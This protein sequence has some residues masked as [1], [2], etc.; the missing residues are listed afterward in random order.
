[1]TI[2]T[3]GTL[4][5]GI[6]ST[7]SSSFT[8]ATATNTLASGDFGILVVVT[9]NRSNFSGSYD[10]T[11]VSGGT[12]GWLKLDEYT[13]TAGVAGD[14]VAVSVWLFEA[15]GTVST[16]TTITITLSGTATDKAATFWKFTK[17][18]GK[19]IRLSPHAN[20]TPIRNTTV[21]S[22]GFGS[23]SFASLSSLSRLYL[24]GLGKEA[25]IGTT[26]FTAST[27]FTAMTMI[28]SR[29]NA[30]AVGALGEFRINTSTGETSNP[31]LAIA[32]DTAGIFLALEE[33][34]PGTD[35]SWDFEVST[36]TCF[37]DTA[38]T[39]AVT[40]D[41]DLVAAI[42]DKNTGRIIETQATSTDRPIYKT[43][44][45]KPYLDMTSKS[46]NGMSNVA[47]QCM[48]A[49]TGRM[50]IGV[51]VNFDSNTGTQEV[52]HAT[53]GTMAWQGPRN[54]TGS[55]NMLLPG[56]SDTGPSITAAQGTVLSALCNTTALEAFVDG[57]GNGSSSRTQGVNINN[58][59]ILNPF[60]GK[61]YGFKIYPGLIDSTT[62]T[63]MVSALQALYTAAGGSTGPWLYATI[64]E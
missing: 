15:T 16:G 2:A 22:N 62:H 21:G 11:G 44:G 14:G 7:S 54:T 43:G 6:S 51:A 61:L 45:G 53:N 63:A 12:G 27:N 37:T 59:I 52:I 57:T 38:G 26:G 19:G 60:A 4:G 13:Y 10:H 64:L 34:T 42:K 49:A 48:E 9:D 5:T 41:G 17:A 40:S 3:G 30:S 58:G 56:F 23:V 36:A 46:F 25:N 20:G 28:R 33:Y 39:T 31:T 24:R 55:V 35:I 18:A 29:N 8:L 1:M 32:G 50:S 47:H